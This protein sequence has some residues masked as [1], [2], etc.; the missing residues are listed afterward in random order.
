MGQQFIALDGAYRKR[1]GYRTLMDYLQEQRYHSN[2]SEDLWRTPHYPFHAVKEGASL[3]LTFLT[4]LDFGDEV[5]LVSYGG[6]S[7]IV[8]A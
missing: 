4:N 3:F 5:G 1:Y 8:V 7:Q 2:Q 6:Y